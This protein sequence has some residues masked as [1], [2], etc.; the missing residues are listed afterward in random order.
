MIPTS[1]KGFFLW[2]ASAVAIVVLVQVS[3]EGY[4]RVRALVETVKQSKHDIEVLK[5][6]IYVLQVQ[7]DNPTR[8][9]RSPEGIAM[10]TVI[11]AAAPAPVAIP[12]P[13]P[14]AQALPLPDQPA[15]PRAKMQSSEEGKSLVNVVLMS[16][17][18]P[19]QAAPG[20]GAKSPEGPK[21]DVQLIGD[22]K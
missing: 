9:T 13:S 21:I 18:K 20:G 19:A 4:W 7:L 6:E 3:N 17:Q 5:R 22:S 15:K 16:E 1:K 11:T 2:M 14:M 10:P 12:M 8:P